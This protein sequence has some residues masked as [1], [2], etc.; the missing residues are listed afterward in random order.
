MSCSVIS[1]YYRI[2]TYCPNTHTVYCR[3]QHP[4]QHD[5]ELAAVMVRRTRILCMRRRVVRMLLG[6]VAVQVSAGAAAGVAPEFL[7]QQ[8][9]Q[10]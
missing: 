10:P 1:S 2:P 8:S 4:R 9:V 7:S 5:A 3:L 6:C